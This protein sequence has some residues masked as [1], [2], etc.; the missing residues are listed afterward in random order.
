MDHRS[1]SES[2]HL[3][4]SDMV[5]FSIEGLPHWCI[6]LFCYNLL[7]PHRYNQYNYHCWVDNDH[8]DVSIDVFYV[9]ERL[10]YFY[11]YLIISCL[12]PAESGLHWY[13]AWAV[14][15]QR[16]RVTRESLTMMT[17]RITDEGC[18]EV[19]GSGVWCGHKWAL[20]CTDGH[21]RAAL[22]SGSY[23][24]VQ[25]QTGLDFPKFCSPNHSPPAAQ[26]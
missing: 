19:A 21:C 10:L 2:I 25:C 5:V 16:R 3:A 22:Q 8:T 4:W 11:S 9:Y 24:Q 17:R 1:Y 23:S 14:R 7:R 6:P 20:E 15:E 13:W 26:N 18:E 12:S